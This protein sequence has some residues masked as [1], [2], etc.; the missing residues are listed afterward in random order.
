VKAQGDSRGHKFWVAKVTDIVTHVEDVPEKIKII[1]Y[2]VDPEGT[3]LEGKY[4]P[5]KLKSSKRF[6][7]DELCLSETTVYAYNF[8][9]LNNNTLP[10]TTRRIIENEISGE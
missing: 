10:A 3:A 4:T 7:E 5:E 1:W 9:L 8:A 6:L 2:T